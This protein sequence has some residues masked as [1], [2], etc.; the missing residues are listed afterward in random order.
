MTSFQLIPKYYF[1]KNSLDKL[2]DELKVK[3]YKKIM[4]LYGGGSIKNNGI[5]QKINAIVN[6]L[7]IEI[8]EFSGIEPNP[9][10]STINK[11]AKFGKENHIDLI[12]AA[13]GGSVIDSSKII[14]A[15]INNNINDCW[16]IVL[17]GGYV[18]PNPVDIFSVITLAGTGSENNAGSVV[19]N[20]ETQEKRGLFVINEVPKVVFEDSQYTL[21]VSEWQVASGIFDC[22]SHLLEQFYDQNCFLWT[23]EYILA[24]LKTLVI[25]A[26][27]YL[28]NPNDI[29]VR[30]NILWTTSMSLNGIASFNPNHELTGDWMVHA[31]EHA[32]S[33]K[34]DVTHGAGLALITPSYIKYRCNQFTWFKEK[35]L[36]IAQRIFNVNTVEEFLEKLVNF[37]SSLKLPTKYTDF[38]EIKNINDG[39]LNELA[40]NVIKTCFREP[41]ITK[42][43]ILDV[44][45][46]I[47]K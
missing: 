46:I 17:T 1:G 34:Y 16:E 5:Y 29:N 30:D 8:V 38:K 2:S 21:T 27:E 36:I 18:A 25:S 6:E 33:A 31:I 42:N 24:N 32:L 12:I 26:N 20:E 47:N 10:R 37:I 14:A 40:E 19:T 11:A 4:L 13:G 15:M 43:E 7:N 28:K 9:H 39:D 44:L 22:F 23:Q 45:K 41:T 35:T 3:K